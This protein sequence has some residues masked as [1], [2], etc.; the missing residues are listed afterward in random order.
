MENNYNILNTQYIRLFSDMD[1][2]QHH[3]GLVKITGL[4]SVPLR[5]Y[6]EKK[7]MHNTKTSYE[8][9]KIS[10]VTFF[11][12]FFHVPLQNTTMWRCIRQAHTNS[13]SSSMYRPSLME[14]AHSWR[15]PVSWRKRVAFGFNQLEYCSANLQ[16]FHRWIIW[17][18]L[19][20]GRIL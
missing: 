1:I 11:S 6:K 9:C 14:F 20:S 2:S 10:V 15:V 17:V 8:N 4:T 13:P 7:V 16:I 18:E 5:I 12:H 3:W 19:Y